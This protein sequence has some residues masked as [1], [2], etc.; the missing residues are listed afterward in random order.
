VRVPIFRRKDIAIGAGGA[1]DD[2]TLLV[3]GIGGGFLPRPLVGHRTFHGEHAAVMDGHNEVEWLAGVI[4]TRHGETLHL[5]KPKA[6][7]LSI[8]IRFAESHPDLLA[9]S[10]ERSS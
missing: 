5:A 2:A 10:E 3:S 7:G 4:A 8:M 1:A 6:E 9:N